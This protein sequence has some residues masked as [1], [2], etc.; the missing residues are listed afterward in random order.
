MGR[1]FI[2]VDGQ[3]V[4]LQDEHLIPVAE[5]SAHP[6]A[7]KPS[8][9]METQAEADEPFNPLGVIGGVAV[10]NDLAEEAHIG[11]SVMPAF[12]SQRLH[13]AHRVLRD[14]DGAA[15]RQHLPG[16]HDASNTDGGWVP[17]GN[18]PMG[19]RPG[20][21]KWKQQAELAVHQVGAQEVLWNQQD[22]ANRFFQ[23]EDARM[24]AELRREAEHVREHV[25]QAARAVERRR[26]V[27]ANQAS[28]CITGNQ[29][30]SVTKGTGM[31]M[32]YRPGS[33]AARKAAGGLFAPPVGSDGHSRRLLDAES[34]RVLQQEV[35]SH[36][37]RAERDISKRAEESDV[38]AAYAA[39]E[40]QAAVGMRS[41][42]FLAHAERVSGRKTPHLGLNMG[43]APQGRLH[44]TRPPPGRVFGRGFVAA[45]L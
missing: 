3:P 1:P 32:G 10:M 9:R 21:A 14:R 26:N 42:E 40:A 6:A 44:D 15:A 5:A 35:A 24:H 22:R 23:K 30:S 11:V 19:C 4:F 28:A 38:E 16:Y 41:R 12:P 7:G 39:R 18:R 17:S 13:E 25:F 33:A 29:A 31:A 34:E 2:V 43:L 37:S 8:C 20:S 27:T 45:V 36:R